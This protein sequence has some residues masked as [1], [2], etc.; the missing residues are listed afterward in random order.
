MPLIIYTPKGGSISNLSFQM[1]Y[2]GT[3]CL[4]LDYCG[5]YD[6]NMKWF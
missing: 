1:N 4:G 6:E 2:F 5:G 3:S